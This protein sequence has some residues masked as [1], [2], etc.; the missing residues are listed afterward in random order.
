ME[1]RPDMSD[2]L[3]HF[4]SGS[5]HEAFQRLQ[6]IIAERRLIGSGDNI[7]GGYS[8]VC[9]TEAPL[10]SL[11]HGLVN[12]TAYSRYAPFG[13]IFEKRWIFE[14][15]GRPVIYQ[16]EDEFNLLSDDLRW[17]HVRFE[18]NADPPIDFTWEREWRV[19][20]DALEFSPSVAGILVPTGRWAQRLIDSHDAEQDFQVLQYAQV[21]DELLAEHYREEFGWRIYA[22]S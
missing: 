22:L 11:Q 12:P 7:R 14:R 8:C 3:V 13:V 9:F 5:D 10:T 6:R 15:G 18:P 1:P 19:Q 4:T 16:P 20:C 21:L 2:K 17:R